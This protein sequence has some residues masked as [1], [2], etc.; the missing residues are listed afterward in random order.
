[1][2]AEPS[3]DALLVSA[4]VLPFGHAIPFGGA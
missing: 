2:V 4:E 1:V 3:N